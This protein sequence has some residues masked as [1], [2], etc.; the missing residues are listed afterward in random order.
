MFI[1]SSIDILQHIALLSDIDQIP[2]LLRVCK[3]LNKR[4]RTEH[5]WSNY[6]TIHLLPIQNLQ[7]IH[8]FYENN[9]YKLYRYLTPHIENKSVDVLHRSMRVF[10]KIRILALRNYIPA[11]RCHTET[12]IN[13]CYE[14]TANDD[15]IIIQLY[16]G[17][18]KKRID[19]TTFIGW[20]AKRTVEDTNAFSE[21][22]SKAYKNVFLNMHKYTK[23]K[24][25]EIEFCCT[26]CSCGLDYL[27][28]DLT[29]D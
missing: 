16:F 13:F 14:K 9:Y 8:N 12:I 21:A 20:E 2:V 6:F 23:L 5:F 24:I 18:S 27:H 28:F 22:F 15:Q 26:Q 25:L 11:C 4:I 1:M 29:K 3:S 17:M 7:D 19:I 10:N